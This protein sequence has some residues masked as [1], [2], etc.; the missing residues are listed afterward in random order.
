MKRTHRSQRVRPPLELLL[1]F[2]L[3]YLLF[4]L[5]PLVQGLR[6]SLFDESIYGG[7]AFVGGANYAALLRDGRFALALFNT[8]FYALGVLLTVVPLAFALA[9]LL[10][11]VPRRLREVCQF[12][13]LLPSL[14]APAALA[15]FFLLAFNGPDGLLNRLVLL[16]LGLPVVNWLQDPWALRA[17]LVMQGVLRWTGLTAFLLAA[18]LAGIPRVYSEMARLE[19]ATSYQRLRYLTLPLLRPLLAFV[20]LFLVFDAFVL[21]DGAYVLLRGSGG[22]TDA[23]LLLVTYS[24]QTAFSFGELGYAAATSY[25]LVPLLALFVWIFVRFREAPALR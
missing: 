17:A 18:G 14:T 5:V 8:A 24:Y 7:G 13:L 15:I 12:C 16:P 21:F 1:P 20:A 22:V 9:L 23:G 11:R 10:G 4:W 25:T 3:L 19:G 6:L 2:F